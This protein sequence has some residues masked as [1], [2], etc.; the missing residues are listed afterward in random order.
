M[1]KEQISPRQLT[2][3]VMSFTIGS[4]I[5]LPSGID[6]WQNLWLLIL[7]AMGQSLVFA[8]L[9]LFLFRRYP[10]KTL[11]EVHEIVYG[12]VIGRLFS[13]LFMWFFLQIGANALA[14]FVTLLKT[15]VFTAT[16]D[17][18]LVI[19]WV[20]TVVYGCRRG[21][22]VIARCNEPL[23][24]A[25]VGLILLSVFLVLNIFELENLLP[26]FNL[27]LPTVLWNTL[28]ISL[29]PFGQNVVFLMLL[30]QVNR[31]QKVRTAIFWGMLA[32]GGLLSLLQFL[33]VGVLGKTGELLVFP[34]YEFYRMI[35]IG[36]VFTRL[37]LIPLLNFLTM[38]FIKIMLC[39]YILAVGTAQVFNL[40]TYRPLVFPL[41]IMILFIAQ[42]LYPSISL[43]LEYIK[44]VQPF[45]SL[46]FSLFLPLL[47]LGV[48][49]LRGGARQETVS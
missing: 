28:G 35:N 49:F 34:T 10:G 41:G 6:A 40:R 1:T 11:F 13:L 18:A 48:S 22:E 16:P 2:F 14:V 17:L 15:S 46:I 43:H 12:P 25:T 47:T 4:W 26:L 33:A 39:L 20:I 21:L 31:P 38:G 3:L 5:V 9:C 19:P 27:P 32:A 7:L 23:L 29:F 44:F 45:F 30:P 36:Q 24:L 42:Q 37:E 8:Y